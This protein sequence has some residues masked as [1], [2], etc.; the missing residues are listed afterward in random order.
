MDPWPPTALYATGPDGSVAC[1][2][3]YEPGG[4]HAPACPAI[5]IHGQLKELSAQLWLFVAT[6]RDTLDVVDRLL[7][8]PIAPGAPEEA[9]TEQEETL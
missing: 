5:V 1:R 4:R 8:V 6:M 2:L 7:R 3:C 9:K